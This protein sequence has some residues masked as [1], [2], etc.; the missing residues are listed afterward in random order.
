M[1]D[2]V[3]NKFCHASLVSRNAYNFKIDEILG[4]A[5]DLRN[6]FRR[7]LYHAN[8]KL[9]EGSLLLDT[10]IVS[11]KESI[12]TVSTGIALYKAEEV[13]VLLITIERL[14][15]KLSKLD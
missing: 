4:L 12:V 8:E 5:K 13:N 15:V 1:G 2:P 10:L 9:S 6:R 11:D 3:C 7:L 14:S